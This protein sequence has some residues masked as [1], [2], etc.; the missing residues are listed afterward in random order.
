MFQL[1]GKVVLGNVVAC[2][3]FFHECPIRVQTHVH[4]DHMAGFSTSKGSQH[5]IMSAPT[6]DLL[7]NELNAELPVRS[8]SFEAIPLNQAVTREN[9]G[10]RLVTPYCV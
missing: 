8:N 2:D 9:S 3:G 5:M 6:R 10:Q 4:K 1:L 7:I